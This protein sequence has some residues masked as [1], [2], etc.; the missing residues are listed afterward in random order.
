MGT[1]GSESGGPADVR[2]AG[3]LEGLGDMRAAGDRE[4]GGS[5][6]VRA[7]GGRERSRGPRGRWTPE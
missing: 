1:G 2:A 5:G 6:D 3:G 4:R 7:S